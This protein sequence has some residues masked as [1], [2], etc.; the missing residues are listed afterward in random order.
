MAASN[1][2]GLP[3]PDRTADVVLEGGSREDIIDV[4]YQAWLGAVRQCKDP[5]ESVEQLYEAACQLVRPFRKKITG[6]LTGKELK[7]IRNDPGYVSIINSVSDAG[8]YISALLN[9]T[10]ITKV[11]VDR[12]LPLISH[13]GYR[14]G[15]EKMIEVGRGEVTW[16]IFKEAT[17]GVGI[18]HGRIEQFM[19]KENSGGILVNLGH[20]CHL[21]YDANGGTF[22]NF[23][24]D[25]NTIGYGAKD[26]VFVS[27][28]M[29]SSG[30][31]LPKYDYG[32]PAYGVKPEELRNDKDLDKMMDEVE[33]SA[34][35]SD[36][37]AVAKLGRK[38]DQYVR[39]HYKPREV[40]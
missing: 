30:N 8:L 35:D 4:T 6:E 13:I 22:L 26:G 38:I 18:N 23:G 32:G 29:P 37:P 25:P 31:F 39:A 17:C 34:R 10:D 3:R 2:Y 9:E 21:G 15:H 40:A 20:I 7:P 11:T 5:S 36:T 19:G 16:D 27:R 12:T 28:T 24:G 1:L 14:L 33:K